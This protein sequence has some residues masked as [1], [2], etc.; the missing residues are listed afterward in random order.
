MASHWISGD[1]AGAEQPSYQRDIGL[2]GR[3]TDAAREIWHQGDVFV[4]QSGGPFFAWW[5]T[6]PW[7]RVVGVQSWENSARN[8]ASGGQHLVQCIIS[9]LTDFP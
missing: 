3:D 1:L 6:E 8:G 2:D 4:G 7:P 9:G 5:D